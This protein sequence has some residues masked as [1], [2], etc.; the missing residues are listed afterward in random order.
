M[1]PIRKTLAVLCVLAFAALCLAGSASANTTRAFIKEIT[2][3]AGFSG[4]QVAGVDSEG[5]LLV[6]FDD[7]HF[8]AKFDP[9]GNPVDFPALES[10]ILDGRG[11][12]DCP[13]TPSDCD[14]V[15][16]DGFRGMN[17][18]G[19]WTK[20]FISGHAGDAGVV[21]AVDNSG[22]PTNGYIYIENDLREGLVSDVDV[23]NSDGEFIGIVDQSGTHPQPARAESNGL[24]VSPNGTLVVSKNRSANMFFPVDG[25][26]AHDLF[27]GQFGTKCADTLCLG[28]QWTY[29][30][31]AATRSN[32]YFDANY[33]THN[34]QWVKIPM[35]EAHHRRFDEP[36]TPVND[37]PGNL[38]FGNGGLGECCG[39]TFQM[40]T[41]D[42]SNEHV[43]VGVPGP[44]LGEIQEWTDDNQKVGTPFGRGHIGYEALMMAIDRTG[45]PDDG[46]VY[47]PG[48]KSNGIAVF[49]GTVRIPDILNEEGTASHDSAH[50]SADL[51]LDGGPPIESCKLEY[52]FDLLYGYVKPCSPPTPY[53]GSTTSVGNDLQALTVDQT[54]HY[55]YVLQTA[56]GPA[57]GD[58]H[59][60][61]TN[62]V[63]G[64]TTEPA[65]NLTETEADLNGSLNP[66]GIAPTRYY[67]EYG[68]DTNY[69]ESTPLQVAPTGTTPQQLDPVRIAGLQP[70]R[71]Y[72][73]RL[74]ANNELGVT[75]G[76]DRTFV[77]PAPPTLVS[78]NTN[79]ITSSTADVSARINDFDAPAT[80]HFEYG[81]T[82]LYG[83]STPEMS[84]PAGGEEQPVSAHLEAL[85]LGSTYHFRVVATNKWGT[86]SSSDAT[87][88]FL[89]PD[90]PNS[91]IR[92][93]DNANYLPDCRAYELVSPE[94]AGN[95]TLFPGGVTEDWGVGF[96]QGDPEYVLTAQNYF[97]M[98]SSP[99][100]FGFFGG[101]GS[102][103][104]LHPP[105]TLLDR[106]VST[107]TTNGWVT[108]Y[109]GRPGSETSRV[110]RP[111]CDLQL[112]KCIDYRPQYT[113]PFINEHVPGSQAPYVWDISG[114]SLGRWP[115]NFGTIPGADEYEGA[116][117]NP[118]GEIPNGDSRPSQDFSH[119]FFSSRDLSFAPGGTV[120]TPGSAYDNDTANS[121]V[122][123]IS[124]LPNGKPIPLEPIDEGDETNFI[125]FVGT[126]FD[127]SHVLMAPP[128][129]PYCLDYRYCDVP[130]PLHLFM[131]VNDAVTYD[132]SQGHLVDFLGMTNDGSKVIFDTPEQLLPADTDHSTDIYVWDEHDPSTLTIVTQGNGRGNTDGCNASWT[133]QCNVLPVS[134]ERP[135]IDNTFSRGNGDIY[136]YSP[137]Q[138]DPTNPGVPNQRNLYTY[139][140]G[141]VQYVT[142][143]DP[144]TQVD[145]MQISADNAH[146]ALLTR[147]QLTPYE[148][149]GWEEMYTWNPES[150]AIQCASCIPT[151]EPPTLSH[152][153][154]CFQCTTTTKDVAASESG[155]FMTSDG[156]VAFSTTD[157]LVPGDTNRTIDV[158]EYTNNRAQLITPGTGSRVK[159][160]GKLFFPGLNTGF[161]GF[162]LDGT[163]LYFSTFDTLVPQDRNGNFVKFYDA[164]SNGGFPSNPPLLP[165]TAADECH[166][167]ATG[168]PAPPAIGTGGDLGSGGN[169]QPAAKHGKKKHKL[170]RR[171]HR[172]STA[173]K[174]GGHRHG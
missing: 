143:F 95:V 25:N 76:P 123:V 40:I 4:V 80:Y 154:P 67:F 60:F 85:E 166:G 19:L 148:N 34:S 56:N 83:S 33:Y 141:Q 44:D 102:I 52:G 132:V 23:F 70:G 42:P 62:S 93:L 165:C 53:N 73:F 7:Q 65:T 171:R 105:N 39:V 66:D 17:G 31:P 115:T 153:D 87:V 36:P 51:A 160:G 54:Y 49:G 168:S 84:L 137:E 119:F 144:G 61:R 163:D 158:Y 170:H 111:Q 9:Q 57:I 101:E 6:W 74:V 37:T 16:S 113:S 173:K 78:I 45:G 97:G 1:S 43:L 172:A 108:T 127:G 146:M 35:S 89:P 82:V 110:S 32:A 98:A 133:N 122:K 24:A 21:A 121:T 109:P 14:Q 164:R 26:P 114:K 147:S 106:Y 13:A 139:R 130:K 104:G 94:V 149:E 50:V 135:V 116:P 126:S 157:A 159:Q 59:T 118:S 96:F 99:S 91:H 20:D 30:T 69:T 112:S 174:Q 55:R 120:G 38:V 64:V 90:C 47:A 88:D 18:T 169:V 81:R 48:V 136:F 167:D 3:P 138:L 117:L 103:S 92:Q 155:P 145:R 151:G 156:R 100:R 77:A 124:L 29:A 140:N 72:H 22:G 58:D 12:N 128:S 71:T 162:S 11:T 27:A 8:L 63:L 10:N 150:G 142:T 75:D 28:V 152:V 129:E 15:P 41:V 2:L 46:Y 134:P 107:R 79:N 161:E 125:H 131:R 5:N 86:T 68:V